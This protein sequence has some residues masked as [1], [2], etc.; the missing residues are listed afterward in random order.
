MQLHIMDVELDIPDFPTSARFLQAVRSFV[1]GILGDGKVRY[2]GAVSGGNCGRLTAYSF[3]SRFRLLRFFHGLQQP[4]KV[5]RIQP[6]QQVHGFTLQDMIGFL[7]D[8]VIHNL[9]LIAGFA[10]SFN[11][12]RI[13]LYL[14]DI[15]SN[16]FISTDCEPVIIYD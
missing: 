9:D 3:C 1:T 7:Y 16:C 14:A 10:K 12:I 11:K 15:P 6:V 2:G 4:A 5:F 13:F 8:K